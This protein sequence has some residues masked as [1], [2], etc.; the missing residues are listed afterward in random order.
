[1]PVRQIQLQAIYSTLENASHLAEIL[2]YPEVSAYGNRAGFLG[3]RLRRGAKVVWEKLPRLEAY[4]RSATG[5]LSVREVG[6]D[7]E[8]PRGNGWTSPIHLQFHA[9]CW[10]HG[11]SASIAYVPALGIEAIAARL[12]DLE[13]IT[14]QE[15]RLALMR[16][17]ALVSLRRLI[18]LQRNRKVAVEALPLEVQL[19]TP[20]EMAR[21][22]GDD[23]HR[24][25]LEEVAVDLTKGR[26]GPAFELEHT[27]LQLADWLTGH[28]PRSVLLV[29]PSGVGKTAAVYELVRQRCVLSLASTPFWSTSGARLVAGMSGYGMWQERCQGICREA[30]KTKAVIHVGNLM[31]LMQVGKYVGNDQGVGEFLRPYIG[32]GDLVVL[33]ECTP[34][35]LTLIER[36]YPA[37]LDVLGQL[38]IKEPSADE[39][40]AILRRFAETEPRGPIDRVQPGALETLDRLHRRYATYSAYPG[41]PL[42]FLEHLLR[43]TPPTAA[44]APADVT[45]AFSRET[46]L[47]LFLLD[48]TVPL[49]LDHTRKWFAER[50]IGQPQALDVVVG[51][52]ATVKAGLTRPDRPIASL[53]FIG[54][55]GVGKTEMARALAE[56]LYQD[57]G[58]MTRIDMSEYADPLAVDRLIGVCGGSEGLLTSKV[59]EQPFGVV[60]LDEFEKAHPRFF[61]LLLQVLGEGRLTDAGGRLADFRNAVIVMTSNLGTESFGRETSGFARSAA[62]TAGAQDHFVRAT[63]EFLRPELFNRVDRI[64]PFLPLEEA[65]LHR[66][67]NRELGLLERREGIRYR[68]LKTSFAPA[69]AEE[70]V[71]RGFD[72]RYGA[73]PIKRAID[74]QVLAPLAAA[75]NDASPDLALQ[76]D[77]DVG[78]DGLRVAVHAW[79]D[80]SGSERARPSP[81]SDRPVT[82][83][84]T[85]CV[86]HRRAAAA[87]EQSHAAIDLHNS[88]FRLERL[89]KRM[90][91]RRHITPRDA[92]TLSRLPL[93]QSLRQRLE[94]CVARA[95]RLEDEV[96]LASYAGKRLD[97][98][99]ARQQLEASREQF[100]SLR[101]DMF[102][103]NFENPD[104]ITLVVYGEQPEQVHRLADAYYA[105]AVV[106]GWQRSAYRIRVVEPA[107]PA[108][109]EVLPLGDRKSPD[110]AKRIQAND[111]SL[112]AEV[113]KAVDDELPTSGGGCVG[114]GMCLLGRMAYPRLEAESGLHVFPGK[115]TPVR[116][117]VHVSQQ[118]MA[119]YKPPARID[120]K[121]SIGG[122]AV[123]RVYDRQRN[124][125]EDKQADV[126]QRWPGDTLRGPMASL[127]DA[128]FRLRIEAAFR[129]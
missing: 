90:A 4:R 52:M 60:L 55:T 101:V 30:A 27:V 7:V 32:R 87:V 65:V 112:V 10:T 72:R 63:E 115:G 20:K 69:V 99:L 21:S 15:I 128:L 49:D 38:E 122:Q 3:T 107:P 57:R 12:E 97:L 79:Q 40:R 84:A 100:E 62:R 34:E 94:Q 98:G 66:I 42:R 23:S 53:L 26:I 39:G 118:P 5:P 111:N 103:L 28:P 64:V 13:R 86:E 48:D 93:L 41:R 19:K 117:L 105:L 46:G 59:R 120:R 123:R 44:I 129:T 92:E 91:A 119:D 89:Q 11:A 108:S 77:V 110:R 81:G 51:L 56:F 73:R 83:L 121:G 9:V 29:G 125:I 127:V 74:R 45:R 68:N 109:P 43:D 36:D 114:I 67:A 50:V 76:A 96:L 16:T 106:S 126:R 54:P 14:Q 25:V 6:I 95:N 116:C 47:P 88:L 82:G 2:F 102:A 35:Q 37:M 17:K 1:M 80:P 85:E 71:R 78:P 70:V 61:D 104:F 113:L 18:W 8:P 75:L 24:S 22:Q 124:I 31:E 58:R 33:A